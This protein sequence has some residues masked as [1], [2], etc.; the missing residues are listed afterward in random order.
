MGKLSLFSIASHDQKI[1][2]ANNIFRET[3]LENKVIYE[4][5]NISNCVYVLKDGGINIKRWKSS[6]KSRQ[7]RMLWSFRSFIKYQ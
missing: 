3:H 6:N 5:D 4:K 7:R 1:K 2:L